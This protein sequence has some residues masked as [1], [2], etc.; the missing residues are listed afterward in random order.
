MWAALYPNP[1]NVGDLIRTLGLTDKERA[2]AATLSGGQQQRLL[3]ATALVGGTP[4]VVLD[5]PTTGLDPHARHE[6]WQL[7]RNA[8][9]DAGTILLSTHGMVE[10]EEM[11]DRIAILHEGEIVAVGDPAGLIREHAPGGSVSVRA[12]SADLVATLRRRFGS[13]TA[14]SGGGA[15]TRVDI[16]AKDPHGIASWISQQEGASDVRARSSTLEDVFLRVT[17]TEPEP[18]KETVE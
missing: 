8:Q 10:A 4:L 9:E 7:I 5:E 1:R 11:C 6:V 14:T 3:V 12:A 2:R 18:T 17:G 13:D 16:R 15:R